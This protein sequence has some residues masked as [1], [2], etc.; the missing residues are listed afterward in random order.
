M[1]LILMKDDALA[2]TN[3]WGNLAVKTRIADR[4]TTALE[5]LV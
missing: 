5:S 3:G 1:V 4:G 2:S